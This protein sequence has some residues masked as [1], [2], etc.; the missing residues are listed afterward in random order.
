M[1]NKNDAAIKKNRFDFSDIAESMQ[2]AYSHIKVAAGKKAIFVLGYTKSGKS[3]LLNYLTGCIY[4]RYTDE[5]TYED[6]AV[7]VSGEE[8]A[9][10]GHSVESETTYPQVIM[11]E[12]D[13]FVYI[14]LP[15]F[16]ETRG[17]AACVL[18]QTNIYRVCQ[19]VKEIKVVA[20]ISYADLIN[21]VG[22]CF[23]D[24]LLDLGLIYKNNL[25]AILSTVAF[26]ITKTPDGMKTTLGAMKKINDHI[27]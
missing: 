12:G 7:L 13:D 4:K 16:G 8:K 18:N 6:K 10:T 25:D 14:D 17:T 23:K 26:A 1:K 22:K 24:V 21:G 9:K 3:T 27:S 15:G 19:A 2:E 11:K 5:E 20:F